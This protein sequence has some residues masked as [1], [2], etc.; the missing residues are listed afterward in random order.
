MH[1]LVATRLP[2]RRVSCN[3]TLCLGSLQLATA[4]YAWSSLE[5]FKHLQHSQP[6]DLSATKVEIGSGYAGGA[7]KVKRPHLHKLPFVS[8]ALALVDLRSLFLFS[9]ATRRC[10]LYARHSRATTKYERVVVIF[11]HK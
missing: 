9:S 2:A 10:P 11:K 6:R 3:S 4:Q 1:F 8:S 5:R 7:N